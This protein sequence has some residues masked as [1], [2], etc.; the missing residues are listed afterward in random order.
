MSQEQ[1]DG[2]TAVRTAEAAIRLGVG[3]TV[4][5]ALLRDGELRSFRVGRA[6]LIPVAEIERFVADRV[7]AAGR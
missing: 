6:V 7:A 1:A 5:R 2:R 4:L 3:K